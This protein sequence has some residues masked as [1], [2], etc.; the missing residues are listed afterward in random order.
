VA[1]R[2]AVVRQRS[3]PVLGEVAAAASGIVIWSVQG[4]SAVT[5]GQRI[6]V[7]RIEAAGGGRAPSDP[8]S[9]ARIRELE[10]LA[11]KDPV[12]RDFLEKELRAAGRGRPGRTKRELPIVASAAGRL[13]P[14]VASRARVGRD[15]SLATIVDAQTWAIDAMLD[16]EPPRAEAA[17]EL[18]GDASDERLGCRLDGVRPQDGGS[19]ISIR[20]A[21]SEAPW[22][23]GA[24]SLRIRV[25]PPGTPPE[26]A[27]VP[28]GGER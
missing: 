27:R 14:A 5:A 3:H 25:A 11:A 19:V 23:E 28:A 9:A 7:L 10:A 1:W 18:R 17:C 26:P 13:V 21:A 16:G 4:G 2:T 15:A 24:R 20:V 8:A 22:L 6:G 12:Y